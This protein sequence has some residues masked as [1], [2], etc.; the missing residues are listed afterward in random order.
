MIYDLAESLAH[1]LEDVYRNIYFPLGERS[2]KFTGVV[3]A[4]YQFVF[5]VTPLRLGRVE[6]RD[7]F[8]F[9]CRHENLVAYA[10]ASPVAIAGDADS[11]NEG[12]HIYSSSKARDIAIYL[13]T[14]I[15][16]SQDCFQIVDKK[17][18]SPYP[19][20]QWTPYLGLLNGETNAIKAVEYEEMWMNIKSKIEWRKFSFTS[21]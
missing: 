3:P 9:L 18:Y 12:F 17:V 10:Y 20:D 5:N 7:F 8:I 21:S 15:P 16:E 19:T 14:E 11:I 13:S 6:M 2:R 4:G 1:D